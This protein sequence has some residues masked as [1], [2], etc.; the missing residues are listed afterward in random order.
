MIEY[1]QQNNGRFDSGGK[2]LKSKRNNYIV[3][4][5][6]RLSRD[7]ERAGE[8]LSIENQKAM[9]IKYVREQGWTLH[10]IYVDDG[11]SGTTFEREGVQRLLGDA[12]SGIINTIVVKDLSRFGRNYI[13]VGQYIDYIFPSF[14]IRFIAVSDNIDTAGANSTAMDM[15]PI[16][17]VFNEWYAANTSRKVRAIFTANARRGKSNMS[18]PPYGYVF[19]DDGK[20]TFVINVEVS[21]N[22]QRI[23]EM[24]AKGIP[25][26]QIGVAFNSEGIQTPQ[27]YKVEKLGK[28]ASLKSYHLW[29]DATVRKILANPAYIGSLA[30]QRR[31]TV[32]YKNHKA[33]LRPEEEWIVTENAHPAII[34]KELWNR[35]REVEKSVS[36]GK[37]TRKGLTHPFSGFLF[38]ADCGAKMKLEYYPLRSSGQVRDYV[39]TFNCGCHKRLGKTYC[40]SHYIKASDIESILLE[41]IKSKS[42]FIVAN[43]AEVRETYLRK[44]TQSAEKTEVENRYELERK[45]KR[46]EKLDLLIE[47]AFE[48]K[49]E[50][51]IP[52]EVCIKL[53][54]KYTAE[55]QELSVAIGNLEANGEAFQQAKIDIEE[56]IDRVKKHLNEVSVTR[57]LC[58]ELIDKIVVGGYPSVTGKPQEIEIYYKINLNSVI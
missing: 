34:S 35:V 58:L 56:F 32:S 4:I 47:G 49:L 25:P 16:T 44:Q 43:E 28:Y 10:D 51:K 17:N 14:G 21:A 52:E 30:L 3:G 38:C 42:K 53:I 13:Q 41:D 33:I 5:Y 26:R 9:L 8:S 20:R 29:T 6:V 2:T 18:Y 55:R 57:E 31:T 54:E 1:A 22:V 24:R 23:F 46:F 36:Q 15:M 48:E 37:Q 19:S 11:I 27:D 7:D 45:K 12:K 40:F 50:G 39:Y